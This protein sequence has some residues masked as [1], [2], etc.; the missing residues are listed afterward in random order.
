MYFPYFGWQYT[1]GLFPVAK[2][3][4]LKLS[5]SRSRKWI[6]QSWNFTTGDRIITLPSDAEPS[7]NDLNLD[8][9]LNLRIHPTSFSNLCVTRLP[10]RKQIGLPTIFSGYLAADTYTHLYQMHRNHRLLRQKAA[11]YH[12]K[13]QKMTQ[14]YTKVHIILHNKTIKTLK[15]HHIKEECK[16]TGEAQLF[17]TAC[18]TD[19]SFILY[20]FIRQH[21]ISQ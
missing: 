20:Y 3:Q 17:H 8:L 10:S 19:M 2:S 15:E 16:A 4:P 11:E 5:L 14:N 12:I 13:T 9:H 1:V 21:K 18:L 6:H 7:E